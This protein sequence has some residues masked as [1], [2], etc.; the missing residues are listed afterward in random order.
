[1][2]YIHKKNGNV[3]TPKALVNGHWK[4]KESEGMQM[5]SGDNVSYLPGASPASQE[6]DKWYGYGAVA[7]LMIVLGAVFAFNLS[8]ESTRELGGRSLASVQEDQKIVNDLRAGQRSLQSIGIKSLP[9]K[10]KLEYETLRHYHVSF[11]HHDQV[12]SVELQPHKLPIF[13]PNYQKFFKKYNPFFS[14]L[15]RLNKVGEEVDGELKTLKFQ[16]QSTQV[17]IQ[18]NLEGYMISLNIK[19]M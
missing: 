10:E 1:M 19:E 18:E 2:A 4:S 13:I 7:S 3:I 6:G 14:S 12:I 9:I 11:D 17:L 15:S 5:A 8:N 16:S